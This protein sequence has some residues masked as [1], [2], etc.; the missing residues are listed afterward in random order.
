M[1]REIIIISS[2]MTFI[3]SRRSSTWGHL[4]VIKQTVALRS[5]S[6]KHENSKLIHQRQAV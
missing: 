6:G 1:E 2:I 4:K 3:L 5:R